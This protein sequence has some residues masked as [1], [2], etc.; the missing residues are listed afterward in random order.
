MTP[1]MCMYFELVPPEL[2]GRIS[3]RGDGGPGE[4]HGG[5]RRCANGARDGHDDGEGEEWS[6]RCMCSSTGSIKNPKI[7][8]PDTKIAPTSIM[9]VV[10]TVRVSSGQWSRY[11]YAA[12]D[13]RAH[14]NKAVCRYHNGRLSNSERAALTGAGNDYQLREAFWGKRRHTTSGQ[15]R[16]EKKAWNSFLDMFMAD[17]PLEPEHD[18]SFDSHE[19]KAGMHSDLVRVPMTA[20]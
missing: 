11:L 9:V 3:V 13:F 18:V 5:L 6:R 7:W 10:P 20:T 2:A 14:V 8:F 17:E 4:I 12:A 15:H 1:L 16:S 19:Y